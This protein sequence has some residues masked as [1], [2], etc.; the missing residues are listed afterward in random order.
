MI[1]RVRVIQRGYNN[2]PLSRERE[3]VC[4]REKER[5]REEG[6]IDSND[7]TINH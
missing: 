6:A 2:S 5:E 4:K 1:K 3:I 7:A